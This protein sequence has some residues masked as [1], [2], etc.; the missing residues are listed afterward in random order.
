MSKMSLL[1]MTLLLIRTLSLCFLPRMEWASEK[2]DVQTKV[3][4]NNVRDKI[5]ILWD[6]LVIVMQRDSYE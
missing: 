3:E 4:R 2:D 1:L 5:L 6:V